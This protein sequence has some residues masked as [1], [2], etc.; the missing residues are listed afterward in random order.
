MPYVDVNQ[1]EGK[2]NWHNISV[3]GGILPVFSEKWRRA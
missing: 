1:W 2:G 3:S